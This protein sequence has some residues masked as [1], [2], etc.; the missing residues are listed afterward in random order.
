MTIEIEGIEFDSADEAVQYAEAGEGRAVLLDRR[1]L[2]VASR[3]CARCRAC[4]HS[5]E[6]GPNLPVQFH[7]SVAPQ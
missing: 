1:H 4:A 5:A 3:A 2:V 7:T 6:I